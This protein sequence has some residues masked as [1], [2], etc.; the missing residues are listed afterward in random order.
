MI[1]QI[2]EEKK[3]IEN[4]I[5]IARFLDFKKYDVVI[6]V[7][8]PFRKLRES[9]KETNNVKEFYVHTKKKRGVE[10]IFFVNIMKNR[11]PIIS[12]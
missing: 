7:V 8:A 11:K 3:N 2:L 4:V 9:L 10:K 5:T 6:S 12:M 1:T